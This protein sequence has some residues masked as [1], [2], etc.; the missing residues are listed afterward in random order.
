MLQ[1]HVANA[2]NSVIRA[3]FPKKWPDLM[4]RVGALVKSNTPQEVYGGIRALLEVVKTYRC[5][6]RCGDAQQQQVHTADIL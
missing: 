6:M 5:V 1:T 2:L 4:D 3:D